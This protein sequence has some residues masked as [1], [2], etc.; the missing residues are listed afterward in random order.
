[1]CR[2]LVFG[3]GLA[4]AAQ[5][6][7]ALRAQ[8]AQQT[9]PARPVGTDDTL[10]VGTT[11]LKLGMAKDDVLRMLSL[12]YDLKPVIE[13]P[14]KSE[15]IEAR[16]GR[17]DLIALVR[18]DKKG[19]LEWA[20]KSWAPD[21]SRHYSD[22]EIGRV[23][24][25]LW[26]TLPNGVGCSFI[27]EQSHFLES[28]PPFKPNGDGSRNAH[29]ECGHKRITFSTITFKGDDSLNITEEI[30]SKSILDRSRPLWP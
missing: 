12:Q 27:T 21:T 9:Q 17:K 19:V 30:D 11:T 22:G 20:S 3:I 13:I 4:L 7:G 18:F 23:I 25:A 10:I 26:G 1:M 2:L 8:G 29:I 15:T 16:T 6:A 24:F 5:S 14:D 28:Q